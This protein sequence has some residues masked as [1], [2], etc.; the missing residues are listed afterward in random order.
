MNDK[1]VNEEAITRH[2]IPQPAVC[3]ALGQTRSG[4]DKLRK[5]DP[6]FPSPISFGDSKQAAN[7]YVV[8]EINAWLRQK[9]MARDAE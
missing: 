4:I 7:Y 5:K 8:D 2:L 6:T 3:K 1:I 9:I